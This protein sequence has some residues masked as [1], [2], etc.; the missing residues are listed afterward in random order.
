[1][2][3][4]SYFNGSDDED[5]SART[6]TATVIASTTGTRKR[7]EDDEVGRKRTR[8]SPSPT[9]SGTFAKSQLW[10]ASNSTFEQNK[11]G[12]LEKSS[13][14][15]SLPGKG[16]VD[17]GND[18]DSDEDLSGGGFI[19]ER[20]RNSREDAPPISSSPPSTAPNGHDEGGTASL[21]SLRTNNQLSSVF[22]DSSNSSTSSSPPPLATIADELNSSSP[23]N[24]TA[25]CTPP[26]PYASTAMIASDYSTKPLPLFPDPVL[27]TTPGSL[28]TDKD[29]R[30]DPA[31]VAE[32][33][34]IFTTLGTLRRAKELEEEESDAGLMRGL[35]RGK[36]KKVADHKKID[37]REENG[38]GGA[39][40]GEKIK[41]SFATKISNWS[42]GSKK[43]ET[44]EKE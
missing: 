2:D 38:E 30:I 7:E 17:Y 6:A 5:E 19:R 32:E 16:L 21:E 33:D 27:L 29:P 34:R 42:S 37:K 31:P 1:M 43:Q 20:E 24:S 36:E 39:K 28:S 22:D 23:D 26:L 18:E 40:K 15:N 35:G 14:V 9:P 8:L 11:I 41:I 4:E 13:A 25:P 3:E 12:S 44:K 10:N